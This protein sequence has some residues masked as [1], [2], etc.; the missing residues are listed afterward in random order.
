MKTVIRLSHFKALA[1]SAKLTIA[2]KIRDILY[3]QKI[4][5]MSNDFFSEL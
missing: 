3:H 2:I 5:K 1:A 4:F